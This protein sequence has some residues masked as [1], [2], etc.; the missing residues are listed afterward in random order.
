MRRLVLAV[1]AIG[2]LAGLAPLSAA[3]ARAACPAGDRTKVVS[4]RAG[5]THLLVPAGAVS[6]LICRYSGLRSAAPFRLT[7]HGLVSDRATVASLAR[8]L[9]SLRPFV[10][11]F[12]C[13]ASTG[14]A[15]VAYFR[16]AAPPDDPVTVALDG[17]TSAGNGHLTRNA[18]TPA[19]ERLLT[20][21]KTL[22]AA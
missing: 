11:V 20:R 7:R 5:A 3:G 21:L 9:D 1:T 14:A 19:G 18:A 15:I 10:G 12:H 4:A 22:A 17:C 16:Y 6:V 8:G 2:L 13:P